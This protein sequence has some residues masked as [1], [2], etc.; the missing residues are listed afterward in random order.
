VV[1]KNEKKLTVIQQGVGGGEEK[2]TRS[3]MGQPTNVWELPTKGRR[4]TE[5]EN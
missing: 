3:S 1:T 4:K 5:E 2:D